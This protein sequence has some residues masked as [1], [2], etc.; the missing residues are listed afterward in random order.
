MEDTGKLVQMGWSAGSRSA[1]QFD[2]VR[3]ITTTRLSKPEIE[4]SNKEGSSLFA[5][6]WQM[7]RNI[8]PAEIVADFNNFTKR[9]GIPRMN[10]NGHLPDGTYQVV[11]DGKPF[12]FPNVE[13]APPGAV[14]AENYSR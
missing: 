8:L 14:I 2:W 13:L 11:V 3:N 6:T 12:S 4:T 9:T 5:Y 7:M 10:G 1:P